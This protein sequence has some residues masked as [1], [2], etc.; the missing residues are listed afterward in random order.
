MVEIGKY[1]QETEHSQNS[2]IAKLILSLV[3]LRPKSISNLMPFNDDDHLHYHY[4]IHH[5]I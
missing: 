5:R 2:Q 1:E 3:E 4:Q